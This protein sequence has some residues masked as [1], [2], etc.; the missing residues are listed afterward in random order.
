[1]LDHF[2]PTFISPPQ[3]I[4]MSLFYFV[5]QTTPPPT[6]PARYLVMCGD[7]CI[8]EIIQYWQISHIN[9]YLGY[10]GLLGNHL[11]PSVRPD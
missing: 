1:M 4:Q 9:W 6:S 2:S 10:T 7:I 5:K 8:K 11:V 3:E